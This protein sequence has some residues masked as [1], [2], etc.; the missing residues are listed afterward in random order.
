MT[1]PAT[2]PAP[3]VLR[4]N[5]P[6]WDMA[7]D[8]PN[9]REHWSA[10]A[11]RTKAASGLVWAVLRVRHLHSPPWRGETFTV[12][13]HVT[14]VRVMGK[15]AKPMDLD[16]RRACVKPLLDALV[17]NG[18]LANDTEKHVAGFEVLEEKSPD[19]KPGVRIEVRAAPNPASP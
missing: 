9:K 12:P 4:L 15:R 17:R 13:V 2:S 6:G 5:L 14:F 18:V 7:R 10:K 16:N 3:A 19:G 8:S 1:T 11:R